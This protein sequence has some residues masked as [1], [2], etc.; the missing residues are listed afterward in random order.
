MVKPHAEPAV[1][2]F[3]HDRSYAAATLHR[4]LMARSFAPEDAPTLT[5]AAAG[6]K[7]RARSLRV[8]GARHA[9]RGRTRL[10]GREL[11]GEHLAG[12]GGR[13][14]RRLANQRVEPRALGVDA[15]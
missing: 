3:L 6:A 14:A 10:L 7:S 11:G 4:G 12:G 13:I 15:A 5:P 1:G 8:G 2:R 9:A